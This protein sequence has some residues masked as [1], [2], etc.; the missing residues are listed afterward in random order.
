MRRPPVSVMKA[1]KV[2]MRRAATATSVVCIKIWD[3]MRRQLSIT[4][5]HF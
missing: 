2:E 5:K 3:S 4:K 1:N